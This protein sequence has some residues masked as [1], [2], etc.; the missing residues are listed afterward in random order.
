MSLGTCWTRARI[1][2]RA[3]F[4]ASPALAS[5]LCAFLVLLLHGFVEALEMIEASLLGLRDDG[6]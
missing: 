3:L 4:L 5:V 2:H 6:T 1:Q